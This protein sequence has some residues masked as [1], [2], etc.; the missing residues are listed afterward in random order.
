M[1]FANRLGIIAIVQ[2]EYG[3]LKMFQLRYVQNDV[4]GIRATEGHI[5]IH[6]SHPWLSMIREGDKF[7]LAVVA[8]LEEG[9]ETVVKIFPNPLRTLDLKPT[10]SVTLTGITGRR[11]A[12]EVRFPAPPTQ[13]SDESTA[14]QGTGCELR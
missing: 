8:G 7:F 3:V 5:A 2:V 9:Y 12:L 10:T 13:R 1:T 11:S 14:G 4:I 6:S